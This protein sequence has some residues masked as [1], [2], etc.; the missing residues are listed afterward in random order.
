MP[1]GR[2][3]KVLELVV[4]ALRE[5]VSRDEFV[6]A[7]DGVSAW[8]SEQ[9]GFVSRELSHDTRANRWIDVL[10]WATLDDA[11]AAAERAMTSESCAPMFALVDADSIL[12]LHGE[13]AIE[14]V[15]AAATSVAT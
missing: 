15:Y 14:P 2:A 8:V 11:R 1:A 10:W 4:F 5:G 7:N 13:P 9:P 3:Q 12:V 6:D